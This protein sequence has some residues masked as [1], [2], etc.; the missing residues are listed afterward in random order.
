MIG[1]KRKGILLSSILII[2][3]LYPALADVPGSQPLASSY[4]SEGLSYED[5][6]IS[7][8]I[9]QGRAYETDY[10]VARIKLSE[11]G[12]LRTA[13]A[14]GFDANRTV[15]GLTLAARVNAVL[16]INGDYFSYI[17]D[18]YLIRNGVQYR[19]LPSGKRDVLL[20]DDRG[21]F[22][23]LPMAAREDIDAFSGNPIMNSF[24]F[25]PA[26]VIDGVRVEEYVENNN[27]AFKPRQR[28]AIAQ[29][30]R[31]SLEYVAVACAGPRGR[32]TGLTLDEFSRLVYVQGVE[33]AYNLDGGNS[34]MMMFQGSYVNTGDLGNIRDI[35]D[36]IYFVSTHDEGEAK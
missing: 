8:S 19:D 13:S 14:R 36:I 23:Q 1:M 21:D 32:N 11:P 16:A 27:A 35:S 5:D 2:F 26:L 31:G 3:A 20:I 7:V 30:K 10:W 33:N 24:N 22:Y 25:G 28:M 34:T 29:V 18:G 17:P 9:T 4:A 12:Q 6:T 15:R